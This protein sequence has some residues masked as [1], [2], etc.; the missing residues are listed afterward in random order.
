MRLV[1]QGNLH[2]VHLQPCC[3]EHKVDRLTPGGGLSEPC[4]G[5]SFMGQYQSLSFV[6]HSVVLELIL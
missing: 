2:V 4:M 5:L 3:S 6:Q 1:R